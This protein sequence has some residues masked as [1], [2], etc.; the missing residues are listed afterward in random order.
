MSRHIY[1]LCYTQSQVNRT[2]L[3]ISKLILAWFRQ[4]FVKSNPVLI[5]IK[6]QTPQANETIFKPTLSECAPAKTNNSNTKSQLP[7]VQSNEHPELHLNRSNNPLTSSSQVLANPLQVLGQI[8]EQTQGLGLG[9]APAQDKNT[10][11]AAPTIGL[12]ALIE[13]SKKSN[14]LFLKVY[15]GP[16][17]QDKK[18]LACTNNPDQP[19]PAKQAVDSSTVVRQFPPQAKH[20]NGVFISGKMSDIFAQLDALAA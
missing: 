4:F 19:T 11:A 8:P 17:F 16:I 1:R 18:V 9:L 3:K 2:G 20:K 15:N 7:K 6:P 10:Q 14:L 12:Q 13:P 5:C